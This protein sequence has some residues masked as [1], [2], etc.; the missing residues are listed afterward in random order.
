DTLGAL[1]SNLIEAEVLIILTDQQGLY[2]ADPRSHPNAQLIDQAQAGDPALERMAG[3][4][5][6]TIGTGGMLTKVRA[7]KRAANSGGHTVIASGNTP[8]ILIRLA[9]G[10]RIGTE[11]QASLPLRS[12]RERWL[13]D[14]L[15][16]RGRVTLDK[17]A[18]QALTK[19]HKSRLAIGVIRDEGNFESGDVVACVDEHGVEYSRWLMNYDSRNA[20]HMM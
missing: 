4:A 15:R 8:D 12:A 10:E 3:G 5:G 16:V 18:I 14:H 6:S 13:V 1:V 2:N 9:A 11:L 19:G 7:A 20:R 17:G